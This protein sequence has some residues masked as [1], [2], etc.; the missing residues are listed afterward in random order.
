[1]ARIFVRYIG[2]AI[3][4]MIP[5][6]QSRTVSCYS[7]HYVSIRYSES[8]R[9]QSPSK[10]RQLSCLFPPNGCHNVTH[11]RSL[12][13]VVVWTMTRYQ[14]IGISR[15]W[16]GKARLPSQAAMWKTYPGAGQELQGP[17]MKEE[18]TSITLRCVLLDD[19]NYLHTISD[20]RDSAQSSLYCLAEQR[21]SRI[22]RPICRPPAQV[23][24]SVLKKC[25]VFC[26]A[27]TSGTDVDSLVWK[28]LRSP[29]LLLD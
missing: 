27:Y 15:V 24:V 14:T 22:R 2:R 11:A 8:A 13:V 1:M 29:R 26:E 9:E 3:I 28:V 4:L 6:W 16:A 10:G 17:H 23:S 20:A 18:C 25:L 7:L 12:F 19:L 21:S 5:L